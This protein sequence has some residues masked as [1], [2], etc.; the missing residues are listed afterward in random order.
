[1]T[2]RRSAA[3]LTPSQA[4][5]RTQQLAARA[6]G[7]W[8]RHDTAAVRANL[9]LAIEK[10]EPRLRVQYGG[11]KILHDLRH[12]DGTL[13]GAVSRV[14][15]EDVEDDGSAHMDEDS[16]AAAEPAP[17]A[18]APSPPPPS[19]APPQAPHGVQA[20]VDDAVRIAALEQ[21]AATQTERR[22]R[23][24][25]ARR[26]RD[27]DARLLAAQDGARREEGAPE[28]QVHVPLW[29]TSMGQGAAM[30]RLLGEVTERCA[31]EGRRRG[32]P[33]RAVSVL[34]AERNCSASV[35]S[36]TK[37]ATMA[38][39]ARG[40]Q[41]LLLLGG[42]LTEETFSSL[43]HRWSEAAVEAGAAP[44]AHSSATQP[45]SSG[46]SEAMT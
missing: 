7:A 28:E 44:S 16:A 4:A 9:E 10:G 20:A 36:G 19:H 17:A 18:A 40:R 2:A 29:S 22:R 46:A 31:N 11:V 12:D 43:L 24:K 1:M 15:L 6:G 37:G 25:A 39:R 33:T 13:L 8:N 34:Y 35:L 45:A 5:A 32:V 27:E 21:K 14:A 23:Q 26:R 30:V 42:G 3:A 41:L 38:N